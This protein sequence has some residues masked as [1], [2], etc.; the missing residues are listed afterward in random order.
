MVLSRDAQMTAT[1]DHTEPATYP[2]MSE[3]HE[4]VPGINFSRSAPA[5]YPTNKA[6]NP[7]RRY[8]PV[9]KIT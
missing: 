7:I 5:S 6:V 9:F 1:P 4:Q 2:P 3:A 8:L